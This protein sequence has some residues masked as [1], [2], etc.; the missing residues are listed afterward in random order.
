MLRGYRGVFLALAGLILLGSSQPPKDSE[1]GKQSAASGDLQKAAADISAAIAKLQIPVEENPPCD[2]GQDNR[3][4]DLCAQWKAADAARDAAEYA[5]MTM[6]LGF[7][8]T[9]LLVLTF[10]ETRKTSRAELRAYV[11]VEPAKLVLNAQTGEAEV[12]IKVS[13]QG[14]T[15]AFK[16]VWAGN[17]V[18]STREAMEK[19]IKVT[20]RARPKTG[21]GVPSTINGHQFA[22][23]SLYNDKTFSKEMLVS[24][25][26]GDT[27][28]YVFGFVW[29]EDAFGTQRETMIC[30]EADRLPHPDE[31]K[32]AKLAE[33]QSTWEVMPFGN[34]ST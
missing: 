20:P 4:S 12:E 8:G 9:V 16:S 32:N 17:V 5:W 7:V 24:C 26:N 34:D 6:I 29:Y 13:N 2:K 10:W 21:R 1:N 27:S 11:S 22:N 19:N 18:I 33:R 25:I 30:Y 3:S 31:I 28:I 15:P 14:Q 23:G